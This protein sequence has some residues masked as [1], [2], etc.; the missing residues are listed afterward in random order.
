MLSICIPVYNYDASELVKSLHNEAK[1]LNIEYEILISDD[2]SAENFRRE[3]SLLSTLSN[4]HYL[5]SEINLGRTGN[6][7]LLF[8]T[9]RYPYILFMD[10]DTKVSKKDY[11]KDY[12]TYC[13]PGSIC[14][15]GHLYFTEKPKDKKYLLHWKVGSN[16]ESI[17]AKI[18]SKNPNNSFMTC[19]FLIDRDI[20]DTVRFDERLQG[21]GNEDTLFG[22]E[23]KKKNI[24]ISHIDNP[25]YHLG[26][27]SS[28]RFLS[29]IEE[30]LR[31]YHKINAL[32]N[33]DPV[34]INS[35]K[36]LRV[37]KKLRKWHL[38]KLC[39]YFFIPS[40]KL[41]YKNLVGRN[42]NLFIFDLYK[43]GYLCY[44]ADFDQSKYL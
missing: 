18:R 44:C 42:P 43:L 39:K 30:G 5:Q 8:K 23:L 31:S 16:K 20:F 21:Y 19:N 10:C 38:N 25:L 1:D 29:K 37:E 15:G 12:L 32:Y 7:N 35:C 34:F 4:V 40:R 11:I 17:P 9:A 24:T 2:A 3:N 33:S 26:L 36:I 6:R 27:E 28:E 13:T 22:I 14:S 41:M